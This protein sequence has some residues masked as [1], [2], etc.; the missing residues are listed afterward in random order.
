MRAFNDGR[1]LETRSEA[2]RQRLHLG[3]SLVDPSRT[4]SVMRI[5]DKGD[6]TERH[7]ITVGTQAPK[8]VHGIV[9]QHTRNCFPP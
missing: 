3:L 2:D 4:S 1:F 8:R 7:E 9:R 6:W 5:D